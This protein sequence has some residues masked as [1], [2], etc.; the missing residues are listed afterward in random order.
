MTAIDR[1][2]QDMID[3]AQIDEVGLWL[4]VAMLRDDFG[5]QQPA[6]RRDQALTVVQK[7]LESGRVSSWRLDV[8]KGQW[9]PWSTSI[10]EM[11]QEIRREWEELGRDPSTREIVVFKG[12]G[13]RTP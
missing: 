5:L 6:E 9:V 13:R 12:A 4:I 11:V 1:L 2:I 10:P 7:M 3:E 8:R